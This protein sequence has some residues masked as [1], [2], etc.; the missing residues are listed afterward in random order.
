VL[1]RNELFEKNCEWAAGVA[2]NWARRKLPASFDA[3]DLEQ[4]ARIECWK[5]AQLFD[6]SLNVPFQGYAYVY[7]LNAARMACRRR[8]WSE[9]VMPEVDPGTADSRP[10]G[11]EAIELE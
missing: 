7:V 5:R 8:N 11:E 4:E 10:F 2:R 1:D 6:D 9:A 3:K